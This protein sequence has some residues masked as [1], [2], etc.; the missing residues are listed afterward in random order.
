MNSRPRAVFSANTSWYLYNY[1]RAMLRT[2]A[3]AG[4]EVCV[5]SPA[6]DHAAKLRGLGYRHE[7]L[8]V[9]SA[10]LNPLRDLRTLLHYLRVYR[11]IRPDVA[12]HFTIKCNLYGSLAARLLNIPHVSTVS[13]RGSAFNLKGLRGL[14]HGLYRFTQRSAARV[15]F[16]NASDLSHLRALGIVSE[17]QA[18]LLP[19]SGVNLARFRPEPAPENPGFTFV[20]AGRLLWE[21]GFP[22]LPEAM[23]RVRRALPSARCLV[24]GFLQEGSAKHVPGT[25]FAA[26]EAEGCLRYAGA[27]EDVRQAYRRADCVVLPTRYREGV[28]KS[29]LEAAAMGI[30]LIAT[31]RPGCRE[32]V[33]PGV[34]GLLCP[35]GDPEALAEAMLEM[36]GLDAGRRAE[37]GR[38]GRRLM[39]QHF[40]EEA[41]ARTFLKLAAAVTGRGPVGLQDDSA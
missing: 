9:R 18:V 33:Q 39:E 27:L 28:P 37:M 38:Q 21:K 5:V 22:E 4:Y 11:R 12:F 10:S 20:F 19:G 34:N 6:D 36:A 3:D 14:I 24:Y 32:A 7:P 23:R 40:D 29:L 17:A 30:P 26:W 13:G 1:H 16:Q 25:R 41:I 2:F 8:P 15:F 35:E 31:D